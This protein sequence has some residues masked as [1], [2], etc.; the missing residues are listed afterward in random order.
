MLPIQETVAIICPFSNHTA[1]PVNR[2]AIE[3]RPSDIILIDRLN[4]AEG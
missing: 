3:E 1:I 4:P 2:T